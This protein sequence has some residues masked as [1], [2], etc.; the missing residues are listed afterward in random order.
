MKREKIRVTYDLET[1]IETPE[2]SLELLHAEMTSGIQYVSTRDGVR[3]DRIRDT[4][5]YVNDSVHGEIVSVEERGEGIRV[6]FSLPLENLD[7]GLGGLTN[8][9]PVVAGEVFNFHFIKS[10]SLIDLVLPPAFA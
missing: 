2:R 4:V 9:W 3:M 10:A 6:T 8:L 5:P 7:V 1:K